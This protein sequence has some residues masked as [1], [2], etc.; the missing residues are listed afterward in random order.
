[1]T[2]RTTDI[3]ACVSG[4]LLIASVVLGLASTPPSALAHTFTKTDGNDSAETDT[5]WV[6][7]ETSSTTPGSQLGGMVW[8]TNGTHTVTLTVTSGTFV[9]DGIAVVTD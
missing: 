3:S 2:R 8:G 1:M 7:N 9:V 5:G 6:V 4:F